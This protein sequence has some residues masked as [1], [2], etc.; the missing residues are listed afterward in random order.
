MEGKKYEVSCL[1]PSPDKKH[2]AVGY[3]DGSINIFNLFSGE[4]AIVFS[5]HK[6]AITTLCYEKDGMQLASGSKVSF[7]IN[8]LLTL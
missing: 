1:S 5:G 2:L 6:S 3:T 4:V 8:I 7:H